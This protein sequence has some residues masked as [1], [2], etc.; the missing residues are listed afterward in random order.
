MNIADVTNPAGARAYEKC[1]HYATHVAG[2][3]DIAAAMV[4]YLYA[5]AKALTGEER[6]AFLD[7]GSRALEHSILDLSQLRSVFGY[8]RGPAQSLNPRWGYEAGIGGR[9]QED[10]KKWINNH[11][12]DKLIKGKSVNDVI[13]TIY[14]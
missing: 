9:F 2:N 5:R 8:Y 14:Q 13:E 6:V 1:A 11:P 12:L 3:R 7:A 10:L 4:A